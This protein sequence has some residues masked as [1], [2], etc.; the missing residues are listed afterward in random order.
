[1]PPESSGKDGVIVA[2]KGLKAQQSRW[3]CLWA[4]VT[5]AA[6]SRI[7]HEDRQSA[8]SLLHNAHAS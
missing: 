7:S 5:Q 3:H 6:T 4:S 2:A 8:P 1:M